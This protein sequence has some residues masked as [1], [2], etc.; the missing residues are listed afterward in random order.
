M[1]R[2]EELADRP[3]GGRPRGHAPFH[4][5]IPL[6][7]V[8]GEVYGVGEGSKQVQ[9]EYMKLLAAWARSWRSCA[10]CRW[11]RSPRPA[12]SA[13]PKGSAACAAARWSPSPATTASTA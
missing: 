6:P 1:H 11:R 4:S 9:A 13:W 10:T 5:L 3:E 12:A 8:L 2:V 7:E